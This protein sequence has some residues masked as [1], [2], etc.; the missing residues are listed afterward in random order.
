[1]RT[2]EVMIED[3]ADQKVIAKR[4]PEEFRG[5]ARVLLEANRAIA[6]HYGM[7]GALEEADSGS[8]TK[9]DLDPFFP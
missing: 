6:E 5:L 1:M 7:K 3:I 4:G 9:S 2:E 8:T